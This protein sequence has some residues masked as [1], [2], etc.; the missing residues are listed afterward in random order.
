MGIKFS[1]IVFIILA[2][3]IAKISFENFNT[4]QAEDTKGRVPVSYS[5]DF[6]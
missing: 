6:K 2:A 4:A 3:F 1:S 5:Q